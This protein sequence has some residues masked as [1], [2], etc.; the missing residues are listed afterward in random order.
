MLCFSKDTV[1]VAASFRLN[2]RR[3]RDC[4]ADRVFFPGFR[5]MKGSNGASDVVRLLPL[6]VDAA[7]AMSPTPH[8][9][10]DEPTD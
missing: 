7:V 8:Y 10:H 2:S 1:N 6:P 4:A 9:E 3:G 5:S